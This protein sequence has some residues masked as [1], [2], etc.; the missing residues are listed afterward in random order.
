M[1]NARAVR[2]WLADK[3]I[4]RC[5]ACGSADLRVSKD[6]YA[7]VCVNPKTGG[8]DLGRGSS[9]VRLRC[10]NCAHLHLFHARQM[11]LE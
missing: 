11:G 7:L 3:G 10:S 5:T 6:F 1:V 2:T 9:V 8:P 4:D